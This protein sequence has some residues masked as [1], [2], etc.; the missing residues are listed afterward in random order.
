MRVI[1]GI[2]P[3]ALIVIGYPIIVRLKLNPHAKKMTVLSFGILWGISLLFLTII[4][5]LKPDGI[6]V[7]IFVLPVLSFMVFALVKY[8]KVCPKCA[9]TVSFERP[10]VEPKICP[11][12]GSG[13]RMS[14]VGN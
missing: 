3:F 2:I 12:C 10:Y 6:P 4:P 7:L 14:G 1:L 9:H 13:Y 5:S 11:K 8:T